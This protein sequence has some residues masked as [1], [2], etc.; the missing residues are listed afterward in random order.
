[1]VD[2]EKLL[3]GAHTS[4]SGGV[5]KALLKGQEIGA[6][7][8]QLFTSNQKQWNGRS[9]TEEELTIWRDTLKD[10]G[11]SHIMSH[12]SYLINLGSNKND[13]LAKSRKAFREE[14]ERCLA[15]GLTYMNFHP[16][17]ATGDA[18]ENCLDRIVE[19]LLILEPLLENQPL[20]LLIE[21]TAGQGTTMG[22]RFEHLSY[23]VEGVKGKIPIGVCIDTCHIFAAGY[24]IRTE[25]GWENVMETFDQVVGWEHLYA[26][27]VNDSQHGLGSRKDRHANLGKGEIGIKCFEVMMTHPKLQSIPKYLETPN[28]ELMWK[29]EIAMLRSFAY[30]SAKN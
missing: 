11:I 19:S 9:F 22:H 18:E 6:T 14:V 26:F 4:T 21:A 5:H 13:L 16:G 10:S 30:V 15:L 8:I 12:D 2:G 1:M 27:H 29:D 17:A 7:T 23:I 28:G 25:E 3:I 20:R 24:D